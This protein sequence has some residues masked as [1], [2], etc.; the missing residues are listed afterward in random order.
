VRRGY[1]VAETKDSGKLA[2]FLVEEGADLSRFVDLIEQSRLAV[3]EL[4]AVM[5]RATVEAVLT[6]SARG[7]AGEKH[8]GKQ[9]GSP[10]RWH[11]TQQGTVS[12]SDRKLRVKKPRLRKKGKGK[13]GEVPV[14]AYEAMRSNASL[15]E[16]MLEILLCGVSSRNYAR[17]LPEMAETVGM[18][19]SQVSRQ[20]VKASEESLKALSRRR[21]ENADLL[22]VYIDGMRFGKHHVI[23]AVGIDNTGRKHVLGLAEGATENGV[24]AKGLLEDLVERGVSPERRRLFVIDGSKALRQAI[25]TVFGKENP[26]QRCRNHK[27][28]NVLGYL[29]EELRGSVSAVMKSAYRL[30][31]REGMARL[32]QQAAWLEKSHPSAAS[33]LLEGLEETFTVNR[34]GLSATLR[35]CLSTTNLIENPNSGVRRMTGR[36]SR[37]RDGR[38]ALRWAASAFLEVERRFRRVMGYRDLWMLESALKEQGGETAKKGVDAKDAAA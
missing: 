35:R 29:P 15:G 21:F 24:V 6:L 36:V 32:K 12:L 4:I 30:E 27:V 18:S 14:P 38:M 11:G 17:V 10:I 13:A 23:A 2:S 34:L 28:K 22:V 31:P 19:K 9:G 7:L 8:Q 33:S 37:W 1:Q 16:R 25:D 26:V 3:D 20:A 5:G